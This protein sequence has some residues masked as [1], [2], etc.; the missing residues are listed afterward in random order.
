MNVAIRNVNENVWAEFKVTAAINNMN[1]AEY[2]AK[3]VKETRKGNWAEIL[4]GEKF[5]T[6][7]DAK[8]IRKTMKETRKI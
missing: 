1:L 2:L 4:F 5:L 6:E 7:E 8:N 3:I